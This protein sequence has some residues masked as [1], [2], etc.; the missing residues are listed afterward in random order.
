VGEG[1]STLPERGGFSYDGMACRASVTGT[2][3]T[4]TPNESHTLR[5]D[6]LPR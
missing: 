1:Q 4:V 6:P 3:E 2:V 5:I